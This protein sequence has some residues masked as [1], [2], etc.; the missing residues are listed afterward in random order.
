MIDYSSLKINDRR[1][2][3][4]NSAAEKKEK[5]FS[6]NKIYDVLFHKMIDGLA[7][8]QVIFDRH[9]KPIK[10]V[11]LD[12]N[13]AFFRLTGLNHTAFIRG[14][15]EN[16]SLHDDFDLLSICRKVALTG[17]NLAFEKYFPSLNRWLAVNAYC[18]DK[19][20]F[21]LIFKD[22]S[23]RKKAEQTL[24]QNERQYKKLA[25]SIADVFFAVDSSLK[26]TYW[27]RAC[28]EYMGIMAESALGKHFFEVFGKSKASRKATQICLNVMR[29]RKP[30]TVIDRLPKLDVNSLFEIRIYPTGN[31]VSV[32]A[33]DV[34]ELKKTERTLLQYTEDLEELL[35]L[36]TKELKDSERLATIGQIAGMIGHDIRNPL[37]S[38][39]GEIYLTKQ[40]LNGLAEGEAKKEILGSI[41][42]V[43]EHINY[44]GKIVTDLQ[45]YCKPLKP[46]IIE[47]DFEEIIKNI[48][49][50]IVAPENIQ[51][52][53]WTEKP[54]PKLMTDPSFIQRILTNLAL[55]GIQAME[56]RGGKLSIRVFQREKT[57]IIAVSDTGMGIPEDVKERVFKPLFTTKSKG[58]GFGLAVVK[59][60]V[61]ALNGYISFESRTGKGTTFIFEISTNLS[62]Q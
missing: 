61:E 41:Y 16:Q 53:F 11:M 22:M 52:S 35:T 62:I 15:A 21:A 23:Q 25:K 59:K 8:G 20:Y 13:N 58:H 32:F 40:V 50:T 48:L 33:Q 28:E 3:S 30:Q 38:I 51:V 5:R 10:F 45:D 31:G 6:P 4:I 29:T 26:F 46:A 19:G 7:Y 60:L 14:V 55:N 54:L 49:K 27:N 34:T 36:K 39:M 57:T 17:Q 2:L 43:E 24:R 37:Q 9:G 42:S 1:K 44:I 12:C 18:I 47:T 56:E